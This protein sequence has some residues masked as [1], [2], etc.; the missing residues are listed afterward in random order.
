MQYT[1]DYD[2]TY[3]I[4]VDYNRPTNQRTWD[5]ALNAYSGVKANYVTGTGRSLIWVC[6]SDTLSGFNGTQSPRTYCLNFIFERWGVGRSG[7][8][9]AGPYAQGPTTLYISGKSLAAIPDAAGT[10]MVAEAPNLHNYMGNDGRADVGSPDF[11]INGSTS[12]PGLRR[13]LHFEGYNYLFADG[14]VKYMIP[15]NTIGT[16]TMTAPRGMWTVAEND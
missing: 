14:H 8:G 4:C 6:P 1:Q 9:F 15:S 2:E 12:Q 3:P 10:I 13:P 7:A 16:G 11:Q 5:V